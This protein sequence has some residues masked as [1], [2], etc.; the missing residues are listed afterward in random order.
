MG[1]S[2]GESGVHNGEAIFEMEYMYG[3][4]GM[5][6]SPSAGVQHSEPI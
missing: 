6:S 1:V 4:V 3:I 5:G 2:K